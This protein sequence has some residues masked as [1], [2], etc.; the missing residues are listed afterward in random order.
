MSCRIEGAISER[1]TRAPA[2]GLLPEAARTSAGIKARK[3]D[4]AIMMAGMNQG[5]AGFPWRSRCWAREP[6][7][8][9]WNCL[10][11]VSGTDPPSMF[12][13]T[14]DRGYSR[15][16]RLKLEPLAAGAERRKD[17]LNL[18]FSETSCEKPQR[19][20]MTQAISTFRMLR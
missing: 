12:C 18:K 17:D 8:R 2:A 20:A 16:S 14:W 5:Q 13:V 7:N 9:V 19:C 6:K 4:A 11:E 3:A 10:I 1:L 15:S